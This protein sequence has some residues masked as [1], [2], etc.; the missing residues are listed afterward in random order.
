MRYLAL[1]LAAAGGL[2]SC[3]RADAASVRAFQS[4]PWEGTAYYRDDTGALFLC[5]AR[6]QDEKGVSLSLA[7]RPSGRW[8]LLLIRPE[9]F[10]NAPIPYTLYTDGKLL[11]SGPGTVESGGQLLSIDLPYSEET[12]QS[13]GSGTALHIS[14]SRGDTV[15]SLKGSA[16]AIAELQRC[17]KADGAPP[18]GR[19][20]TDQNNRSGPSVA[21]GN[22]AHRPVTRD[23]LLPYARKMLENAG[24]ADFRF[25]PQAVGDGSNALAWRFSNGT[26]GSLAAMEKSE[27]GDLDRSAGKMAAADIASCEGEFTD[28]KTTPRE[29]NGAQVRKAFASCK[30]GPRSFYAEHVLVRMADGFLVKLTALRPGPSV[31][32]SESE[33]P[34][35]DLEKTALAVFSKP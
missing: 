16:D 13:L 21:A 19:H 32:S 29:I 12:I 4:G 7:L 33:P 8:A 35:D 23:E 24:F 2:L 26:F 31:I 1:L 6:T 27:S 28:G 20:D 17:A 10:S 15:L 9:G 14:S 25:L 11:H 30:A 5:S 34:Q 18:V 22:A 3:E